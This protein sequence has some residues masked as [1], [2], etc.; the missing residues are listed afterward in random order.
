MNELHPKIRF[1]LLNLE[2]VAQYATTFLLGGVQCGYGQQVMTCSSK[3]PGQIDNFC[4]F[5]LRLTLFW[6]RLNFPI[7]WDNEN[8]KCL[9]LSMTLSLRYF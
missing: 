5:P 1:C 4:D 9:T 7:V 6:R 3:Q 2:R 8:S